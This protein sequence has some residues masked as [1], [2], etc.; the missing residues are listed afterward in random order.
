LVRVGPV[1]RRSPSAVLRE[2][3]LRVESDAIT[4]EITAAKLKNAPEI[5]SM[6]FVL[7][8]FETEVRASAFTTGRPLP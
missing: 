3:R 4:L 8:E 1:T 6:M 7:H 2:Q 5:V